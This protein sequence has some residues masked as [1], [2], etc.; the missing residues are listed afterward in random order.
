M[1]KLREDLFRRGVLVI[2]VV[3]SFGAGASSP[4]LFKPMLSD[5]FVYDQEANKTLVGKFRDFNA[6]LDDAWFSQGLRTQLRA[7]KQ[8]HSPMNAKVLGRVV[9]E[10][11]RALGLRREIEVF[12]RKSGRLSPASL[13]TIARYMESVYV[14]MLRIQTE[15]RVFLELEALQINAALFPNF[16]EDVSE[17]SQ[18][19]SPAGVMPAGTS[20]ARDSSLF[21]EGISPL[22]NERL[23]GYAKML[24]EAAAE[25]KRIGD[26]QAEINKISREAGGRRGPPRPAE[27][28]KLAKAAKIRSDRIRVLKEE[29]EKIKP[30]QQENEKE[31]VE[32]FAEASRLTTLQLMLSQT[33][34]YRELNDDATPLEMQ[35]VAPACREK[36]KELTPTVNFELASKDERFLNME[37]FLANNGLIFSESE[38][39]KE[40]DFANFFLSSKGRDPLK[41]YMTGMLPFHQLRVAQQGKHYTLGEDVSDDWS[42]ALRP[43]LKPSWVE[44]GAPAFDDVEHF[45][46]VFQPLLQKATVKL[47]QEDAENIQSIVTILPPP[48]GKEPQFGEEGFDEYV[49]AMSWAGLTPYLRDKLKSFGRTRDQWILAVPNEVF[50]AFTS[51]EIR[52]EFP[53]FYGPEPYKQWALRLMFKAISNSAVNTGLLGYMCRKVTPTYSA[54]MGAPSQGDFGPRFSEG[55]CKRYRT[56]DDLVASLR[57]SLAPFEDRGPFVPATLSYSQN[58]RESWGELRQLWRHLMD[59]GNLSYIEGESSPIFNEFTFMNGQYGV[60]PWVMIRISVLVA[61]HELRNGKYLP[62]YIARDHPELVPPVVV[63]RGRSGGHSPAAISKIQKNA[64]LIEALMALPLA[65]QKRPVR[66]MYANTLYGRGDEGW[67]FWKDQNEKDYFQLWDKIEQRYHDNNA[68][69]FKIR[70]YANWDHYN[71]LERLETKTLLTHKD[72]QA[73]INGYRLEKEADP[74]EM[75]ELLALA[76]ESEDAARFEV[77]KRIMDSPGK[78]E[79]H[80]K[81]LDEYVTTQGREEDFDDPND[82]KVAF[83]KRDTA[84]KYPLMT[85]IMKIAARKRTVELEKNM[86]D[87]CRLNSADEKD[88]DNLMSMTSHTQQAF[89]AAFGMDGIPPEVMK[90]Y[91]RGEGGFM[92]MSKRDERNMGLMIFGFVGLGLASGACASGIGS[93][94]GCPL[95][96][97]LFTL[98]SA[99][100]LSY[101]A[102]DFVMNAVEKAQ[103]REER[104]RLGK[105]FQELGFTDQ[106]AV[107]RRKGA[108]WGGVAWEVVTAGTMF[109][110]VG[111]ATKVVGR[112]TIAL[113]TKY[114]IK[115]QK[116][117]KPGVDL[118]K[119]AFEAVDINAAKSTLKLLDRSPRVG[120]LMARFW[121][122]FKDFSSPKNYWNYFKREFLDD[123]IVDVAPEVIN[124]KTGEALAKYFKENPRAFSSF[125]EGNLKPRFARIEKVLA[126]AEA[127]G[128]PK[129]LAKLQGYF[130]GFTYKPERLVNFQ[131]ELIK[132]RKILAALMSDMK[133]IKGPELATYIADH[134][135]TLAPLMSEFTFHWWRLPGYA[136]YEVFFHGAP[137]AY[138]NKMFLQ[139]LTG[140]A[141]VKHVFASR[142][143]LLYHMLRREAQEGLELGANVAIFDQLKLLHSSQSLLFKTATELSEGVD[144]AG[145]DLGDKLIRDWMSYRSEISTK[146]A[147]KI[148]AERAT[149]QIAKEIER[150]IFETTTDQM[151]EARKLTRKLSPQELFDIADNGENIDLLLKRLSNETKNLDALSDY[152]SLLTQRVKMLAAPARTHE[153][154]S[155]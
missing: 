119:T 40:G 152:V 48:S 26:I 110:P 66:P 95:A 67:K 111:L 30:K 6:R 64:R 54:G 128:D 133:K 34:F 104:M 83:L 142:E 49:E 78:M 56:N 9:E 79:E 43:T 101:S 109:V 75:R 35:G 12:V 126:A 42:D 50:T 121:T 28:E 7:L 70:T 90:F 100:A 98:V 21:G 73:V 5:P 59:S 140:R 52:M 77:I 22:L 60:N 154:I 115:S 25:N 146:I 127:S 136:V 27:M 18:L 58:L 44:M 72:V 14:P 85:Q 120:N 10:A 155:Y 51:N 138:T 124:K 19:R 148:H 117:E 144:K 29:L 84:Y 153:V 150:K 102:A 71:L 87:L 31:I 39:L 137:W 123:A 141:F 93:V 92:G 125:V 112:Q 37:M 114:L 80:Q 38:Y 23:K 118:I 139:G 61:L 20:A 36:Y 116:L 11:H 65:D 106:E 69:I 62:L 113:G 143:K 16:F 2:S 88:W 151:L 130:H 145:Q 89:N 17:L 134:A 8:V 33:H 3:S 86:Q 4:G 68:H 76:D 149:A 105:Q 94:A 97:T 1:T 74:T 108:G 96:V 132:E 55:L 13:A 129:K 99:G 103:G 63:P 82:V 53:P 57:G 32:F 91:D 24:Q 41:G 135:D 107:N 15:G 47:Q 147:R 46:D 122:K 45:T 131:S 81:I